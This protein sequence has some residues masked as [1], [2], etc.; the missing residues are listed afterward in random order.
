MLFTPFSLV[1]ETH[2]FKDYILDPLSRSFPLKGG[3]RKFLSIQ[4]TTDGKGW[5]EFIF[6]SLKH[7]QN[8]PPRIPLSPGCETWGFNWSS[9]TPTATNA[10]TPGVT[11]VTLCSR[12][13]MTAP[14]RFLCLSG[15]SK[16]SSS[17]Q[18]P[19]MMLHLYSGLHFTE[20]GEACKTIPGTL[21]DGLFSILWCFFGP[22]CD[23][24]ALMLFHQRL[25]YA[26]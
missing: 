23:I 6:L 18:S 20:Q 9:D 3:G 4:D 24:R 7:V 12:A 2:T 25:N 19:S 15:D 5:K 17:P 21:E 13:W 26:I 10:G 11:K 14:T 8:H 1:E 16:S 22:L